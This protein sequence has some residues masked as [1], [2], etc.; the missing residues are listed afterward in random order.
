M[1]GTLFN[2]CAF[3]DPPLGSFGSAGRNIIQEPGTIAW[4]SS[5]L[6]EFPIS[7]STHLEFRAEFFNILNHANLTTTNLTYGNSD[8]GF[9]SSAS[10][11]REI[12][13]GLKLYF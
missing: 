4:D 7:G 3:T 1:P 6:K 10:T 9:P 8:F 5:L 2:T 11:Q 12:Q 13:G